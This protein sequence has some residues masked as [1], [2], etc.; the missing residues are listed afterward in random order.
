LLAGEIHSD[1]RPESDYDLSLHRFQTGESVGVDSRLMGNEARFMNDFRGVADKPNA[2]FVDYRMKDTGELR[3][4]VWSN[5]VIK[6]NEEIVCSYGK[7]FWK[8]RSV[9]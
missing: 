8:S 7:G 9:K 5:R 3:M 1:E 4:G 6:K 2:V